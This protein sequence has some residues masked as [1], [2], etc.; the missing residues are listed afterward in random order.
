MDALVLVQMRYQEPYRDQLAILDALSDAQARTRP[1]PALNS[2]VWLV[3][4]LARTEDWYVNRFVV[5][6]SQVL[7]EGGWPGQLGIAETRVGTAL[8]DAE[9]GDFAARV[10]LRALRAYRAAVHERTGAVLDALR[11]EELSE[12]LDPDRLDRLFVAPDGFGEQAATLPWADAIRA[13]WRTLPRGWFLSQATLI[14]PAQHVGELRTVASLSG[15]R[16]I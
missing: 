15:W 5:D 4:H 13:R 14:H 2:P 3:W 8:S 6:Q 10:D 16:G 1:D 12:L 11:P 9:I 7:E